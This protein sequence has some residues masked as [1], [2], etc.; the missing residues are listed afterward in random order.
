M[1]IPGVTILLTGFEFRYTYF[2]VIVYVFVI[3]HT[4]SDSLILFEFDILLGVI[5]ILLT[6]FIKSSNVSC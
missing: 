6:A 4:S 3:I 2:L 5:S 1:L